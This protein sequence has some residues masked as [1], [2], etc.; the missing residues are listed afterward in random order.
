MN[1]GKQSAF[2]TSRALYDST[3]KYFKLL[4]VKNKMLVT[5]QRDRVKVTKEMK[6]EKGNL[7]KKLEELKTK[8]LDPSIKTEI[9]KLEK[10]IEYFENL[11]H[12]EIKPTPRGVAELKTIIDTFESKTPKPTKVEKDKKIKELKIEG[13]IQ[14]EIEQEKKKISK[15]SYKKEA[16]V[17]YEPAGSEN[18]KQTILPKLENDKY[19]GFCGFY[20]ASRGKMFEGVEY[21]DIGNLM[22][23]NV[24]GTRLGFIDVRIAL[25][26]P[27]ALTTIKI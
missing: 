20:E 3:D 9:T 26:V 12:F 8:I 14:Y 17:F 10:S 25:N 15:F 23:Y 11:D 2:V 4:R 24:Y 16:L 5:I 21:F 22:M 27:K 19:D 13:L 6:T 18:F 7:K 1:S